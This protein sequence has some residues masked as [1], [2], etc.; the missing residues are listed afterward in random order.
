MGSL[1]SQIGKGAFQELDQCKAVDQYV[2]ASYQPDN[3]MELPKLI[4]RAFG[5]ALESR[6]G[7]VYVDLPSDILLDSS[8]S[9]E[10]SHEISDPS[11]S[12]VQ[13]READANLIEHAVSL[14]KLS[15]RYVG[16]FV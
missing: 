6:P 3:L 2:K 16:L 12:G 7:A 5:N 15:K 9:E 8:V 11:V 13:P 1:Q 4:E 14:I 10:V